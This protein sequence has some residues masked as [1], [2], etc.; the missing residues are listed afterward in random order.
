MVPE[1]MISTPFSA[2]ILRIENI[3]SC[4]RI[5]DAPST[6]ISSA[7]ATSSAGVFFFSSF[8]CISCSFLGEIMLELIASGHKAGERQDAASIGGRSPAGRK[9]RSRQSCGSG[10]SRRD[11]SQSA[12]NKV[13]DAASKWPDNH[14]NDD[15][16]RGNAGHLID[17]ADCP[18]G[19]RALPFRQFL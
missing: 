2:W 17:H 15:Q 3:R 16:R 19:K 8:K 6:P 7:I 9:D 11:R 10:M 18:A 12:L 4:L 5:V 13:S 14:Q 1:P